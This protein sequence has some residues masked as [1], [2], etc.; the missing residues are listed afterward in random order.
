M[1]KSAD[2]VKLVTS[3]CQK[4]AST[5]KLVWIGI[6]GM[7]LVLFT[8]AIPFFANKYLMPY[9][10]IIVFL[11]VTE[12]FTINWTI[13][14]FFQVLFTSVMQ[15]FYSSYIPLVMIAMHHSSCEIEWNQINVS[16]LIELT[17]RHA[18]DEVDEHLK[19]T[20]DGISNFT[21]W[22]NQVRKLF[23]FNCLLEF[24]ILAAL[25]GCCLKSMSH[26]FFCSYPA[27]MAINVLTSQLFAFGWLGTKL[28]IRFAKLSRTL[29]NINWEVMNKKQRKSLQLSLLMSQNLKAFSAVFMRCDLATAQAV[30]DHSTDF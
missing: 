11:P 15:V 25:L 16:K 1:A 2:G 7:L 3:Y 13:N 27:L 12:A 18:L 8:V 6:A 10:F 20:V 17:N 26:N 29:Y 19:T 28:E 14:Y 5:V 24:T 30:G 23:R 22:Q 4:E 9:N 21:I